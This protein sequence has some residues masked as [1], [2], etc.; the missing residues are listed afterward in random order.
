LCQAGLGDIEV[1]LHHNNDDSTSLRRRFDDGLDSLQAHGAL[2]SPD[3]KRRFA[4]IHGNWALDN[5]RMK[6]LHDYCGV[7]NEI[8]ILIEKG[9]YADFT[10]PALGQTAQ[11]SLVNKIYYCVD[12][13]ATPKSHDTG[14]VTHVG[15]TSRP[16][17]LMIFEGPLVLDWTNWQFFTHPNFEDGNLYWEVRSCLS[18]FNIW[19][20]ANIH[21]EGRPN[22]VF[23][24]P[25]TH[26][27]ALHES[28]DYENI[29]GDNFDQML[30]D[31]ENEYNDGVHYRLHYM[32]AREAYNVVKAA[33]A[34]LDGN[35][36]QYRNYLVPPYQY[37]ATPR[38]LAIHPATPA[39]I[40]QATPAPVVAP[41]ACRTSE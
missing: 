11:P 35:P 2:I 8:S 28:G 4:F 32:T 6:G 15:Y 23:V 29:I 19:L 1:H 24:R 7:N 12:D 22:W 16:D 39:A 30:T 25:F 27:C 41:S 10:F 14:T 3:G 18:R 38:A 36:N 37:Q 40:G 20:D 17:Q 34:G 33:E 9:C 21:V 13:P 5:S 26:G 31:L